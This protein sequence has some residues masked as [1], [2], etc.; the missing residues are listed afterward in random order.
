MALLRL[1]ALSLFLASTSAN[2]DA[3]GKHGAVVSEV[4]ECSDHGVEILKIGGSAADAII[5]TGLC[6]GVIGAFHSGIGG[7]GFMIVRSQN[8]RRTAYE[9]IDF[10]EEMPALGNVTMYSQNSNPTASTI[11]GLSVGIPGELRGW[12]LLHQRHGKL[13]WPVLFIPAIKVA[14]GGFKVNVDLAAALNP[15]TYPFLLSDPLWA[16]VYAP[17]GKVATFNQ[18]IYRK[19]YAKT[20]ETIAA[21]GADAFYRG[22]IAE[23]T[24]KAARKT[25]GILTTQ[26]LAKYKAILRQPRNITYR[27]RYRIF[28]T[29]A[30][31]SGTVVLSALKIFDAY[32][33][34]IETDQTTH[35]LIQST[36][37]GY[38]QRT[39][40]GDPA[41]TKNVTQLE[42]L[43]LQDSTVA[44]IRARLPL[45]TTFTAPYYIPSNYSVLDDHGTSHMAAVDKW[46]NAVSLTSTVNLY[47][48]SR[49]MTEDG[50][51]LNDEMDDFSSPNSTNSFGFP[52]SP[53][54]F[55]A[56]FKRPQ[57]SISSSIAEDLKTG[58]FIMATGSAGGSRIITA[59]L[60]NLHHHL[61]LGLTA[62]QSAF[63]P[64]WHDQLGVSTL[65]E[66]YGTVN[67]AAGAALG[68]APFS[69]ATIGYLVGLGYNVSTQDYTGS[70]SHVIVKKDSTFEASN[71]PRKSAGGGSAY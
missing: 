60:Q 67:A 18:T 4:K 7:G 40:F 13:P 42:G 62:V 25:G 55:I 58:E 8:G 19:R 54:N 53:I 48:G 56:P 59:T 65:F 32:A 26:D 37:F 21:L 46:G 66:G 70:T 69:N 36:K 71:D 49:V 22:P 15:T 29:V 52:A 23:N 5:A 28:S 16:E 45:N 24:S 39:T 35:A 50:F 43:Y 33:K 20:L 61:D 9:T 1:L 10:R 64:R 6:V 27:G 34:D 3:R 11:G 47:W 17:N 63:T 14:R 68:I 2:S 44:S 31:S 51:V 38:G 30:P 12:Q 41:F 57:S